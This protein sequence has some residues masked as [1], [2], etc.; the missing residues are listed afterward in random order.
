MSLGVPKGS[1]CCWGCRGIELVLL[2]VL[3]EW[4]EYTRRP[5][6]GWLDLWYLQ[7]L[8]VATLYLGGGYLVPRGWPHCSLGVVTLYLV[9]GYLVLWG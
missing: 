3:L 8:G 6:V 9:G 5:R 1:R 2:G 7:T 4:P